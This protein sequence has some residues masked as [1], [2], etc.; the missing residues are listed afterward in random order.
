MYILLLI[1]VLIG[2]GIASE[3]I[4]K[5]RQQTT[6]PDNIFILSQQE[7]SPIVIRPKNKPK[8]A[9]KKDHIKKDINKKKVSKTASKGPIKRKK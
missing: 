8:K 4:G 7:Q 5:K 9:I 3:L 2:L 6:V 1:I